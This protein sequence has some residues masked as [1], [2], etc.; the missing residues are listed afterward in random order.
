MKKF[1]LPIT[2]FVLSLTMIAQGSSSG[3]GKVKDKLK[4]ERSLNSQKKRTIN[5]PVKVW[6]SFQRDYPYATYNSWSE[7]P[8][9]R[10]ATFGNMLFMSTALYHA[11]GAAKCFG[12]HIQTQKRYMA[13]RHYNI[14]TPNTIN[15]IFRIKD[16]IQGKSQ[17]FYYDI[18][19]RLAK[20][21]Y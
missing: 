21:N 3:E 1:L 9:N 19:S 5:Q 4:N 10:T 18:D 6:A 7:Y 17:Y 15:D 12:F 16:I 2:V 11:N 13:G 20:N 8:G 14:E